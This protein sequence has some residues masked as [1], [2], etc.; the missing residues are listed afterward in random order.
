M[1]FYNLDGVYFAVQ[2]FPNFVVGEGKGFAP[3][4]ADQLSIDGFVQGIEGEFFVLIAGP[5]QVGEIEL[6]A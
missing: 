4:K 2:D 6:F 5:V 1:L 3:G